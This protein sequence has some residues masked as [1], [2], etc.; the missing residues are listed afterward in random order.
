MD[1]YVVKIGKKKME[2]GN[3]LIEGARKYRDSGAAKDVEGWS[4]EE[5]KDVVSVSCCLLDLCIPI[6]A[7]TARAQG[8]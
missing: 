1:A 6:N 5:L 7:M 2:K 4:V 8:F 3:A